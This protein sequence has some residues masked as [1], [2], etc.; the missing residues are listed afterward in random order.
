MEQHGKDE[1]NVTQVDSATN[2][3]IALDP[4]ELGWVT[5]TTKYHV[6][7]QMKDM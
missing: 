2:K 5:Q 4:K 3:D 1:H 7:A 6:A